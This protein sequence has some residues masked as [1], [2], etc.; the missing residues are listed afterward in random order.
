[1][2]D[3]KKLLSE[4][5]SDERQN[6]AKIFKCDPEVQHIFDHIQRN[7]Q[8]K[9]KWVFAEDKSYYTLLKQVAKNCKVK[10]YDGES[11]DVIEKKLLSLVVNR[12]LF[13]MSDQQKRDFE[14][15]IEDHYKK[16]GKEY[17]HIGS[18]AW[19]AAILSAKASVLEFIFFPQLPFLQH[20]GFLGCLSGLRHILARPVQ[21][22]F[23]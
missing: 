14:D 16:S 3:L 11:E 1:M 19:I 17:K 5:M 9:I 13:E 7:S 12:A 10:F 23:S 2:T 20:Q 22:L 21:L 6:M 18:A 15:A 8:N 4:A